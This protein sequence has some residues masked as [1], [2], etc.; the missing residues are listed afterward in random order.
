LL[1]LRAER[2][3]PRTIASYADGL[4]Q[5]I[6]AAG[7][8]VPLDSDTLA[9]FTNSIL[10]KGL[11]P[12]TAR[13][14]QLA[15]R[16]FTA[17][18]A[19]EGEI[20]YNALLGTKLPRLDDKIIPE[21]TEDEIRRLIKTCGASFSGRRDEAII[22]LMVEAGC[23]SDEVLNMNM[24]DVDLARGL[25]V[26]RKAKGGKARTVA[27]GPATGAAIDRYLRARR[28][29]AL[30]G[31]LALWLGERSRRF[32]NAALVAWFAITQDDTKDVPKT[33]TALAELFRWWRLR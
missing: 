23:R 17:W 21:L 10:D 14:R 7:D 18:C 27:F 9:A 15:V 30:A 28:R 2:K 1:R 31:E 25:A 11:S 20:P 4:R 32:G 13:L 19:E 3:S 5:Y 26:V 29:H 16:R 33:V 8:D 22:R 12:S 24:T 6:A